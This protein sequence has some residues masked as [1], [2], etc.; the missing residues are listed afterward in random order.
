MRNVRV[1]ALQ[2]AS[3]P[4]I[5]HVTSDQTLVSGLRFPFLLGSPG[6]DGRCQKLNDALVTLVPEFMSVPSARGL[7]DRTFREFEETYTDAFGRQLR[8]QI[9]SLIE[10]AGQIDLV[11]LPETSVPADCIED[12]RNVA[13]ELNTNIVAGTHS[14]LAKDLDRYP[15]REQVECNPNTYRGGPENFVFCPVINR[16]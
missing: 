5:H 1:A 2:I 6:P 16:D 10:R 13:R 8:G 11:V 3:L 14:V 4:A 7:I 15:Y 12:L 9:G